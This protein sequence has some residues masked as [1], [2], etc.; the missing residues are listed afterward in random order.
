MRA[1][2]KVGADRWVCSWFALCRAALV[3]RVFVSRVVI[4]VAHVCVVIAARVRILSSDV[5]PSAPVGASPRVSSRLVFGGCLGVG[6]C[7]LYAAARVS[8]AF[9]SRAS[10]FFS[11]CVHGVV[12]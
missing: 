11:R 4:C 10:A 12:S 6:L 7:R 9:R 1:C 3:L 2:L 8:C 5:L